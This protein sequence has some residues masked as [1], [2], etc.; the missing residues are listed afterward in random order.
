MMKLFALAL[1]SI[2]LLSFGC[3]QIVLPE[4]TANATQSEMQTP[5]AEPSSV[6]T[7]APTATPENKEN[8]N[9]AFWYS[10]LDFEKEYRERL[11]DLGLTMIIKNEKTF[12]IQTD[13]TYLIAYENTM[14]SGV[15]LMKPSSSSKII[16]Q[17]QIG[18]PIS[19][20]ESY[21]NEITLATVALVLTC[22]PTLDGKD[23]ALEIIKKTT[24]LELSGI[25]EYIYNGMKYM[26]VVEDEMYGLYMRVLS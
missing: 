20:I 22:D 24:E 11:S 6:A 5:T 13:K 26:V 4:S 3:V 7:V 10:E 23:E 8:A 2:L 9:G 1:C 19:S 16:D 17:A 15:V 25:H 14:F 21:G 18:Y 12:D